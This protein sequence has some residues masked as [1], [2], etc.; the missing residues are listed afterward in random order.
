MFPIHHGGTIP[1]PNIK[2]DSVFLFLSPFYLSFI[3][4]NDYIT[5][6]CFFLWNGRLDPPS[7]AHPTSTT[8]AAQAPPDRPVPRHCP[9]ASFSAPL[10]GRS[11]VLETKGEIYSKYRITHPFISSVHL[12]SLGFLSFSSIRSRTHSRFSAASRPIGVHIWTPSGESV[13]E[14]GGGGEAGDRTQGS[15]SK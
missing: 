6:G 12:L 4:G 1:S 8:R 10:T 7:T 5:A 2:L 13:R 11:H 9:R 15:I 14:G 3:Y